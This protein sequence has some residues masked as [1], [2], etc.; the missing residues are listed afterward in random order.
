VCYQ[1]DDLSRPPERTA[2]P[3][4]ILTVLAVAAGLLRAWP[5]LR[6]G[7]WQVPVDYDEGVYSSAA[8]LLFRGVLP[9]RD[10]VFVHPPG[11]L[12]FLGTSALIPKLDPAQ[13]F[14]ASRFIAAAVGGFSVFLVGRLAW[15]WRGPVAGV[16]A[17]LLYATY[18]E[19][20]ALEHGPFLEPVL[21][22][23]CLAGAAVWLG[24][25]SKRSAWGA[26]AVLGYAVSVKLTGAV[27]VLAALSAVPKEDKKLAIHLLAAVA[28]SAAVFLLPLALSAP[29]EFFSQVVLFH[30][31]RPVDGMDSRATRAAEMLFSFRPGAGVLSLIGALLALRQ[32][33]RDR[34]AR[35]WL[36]GF[37]LVAFSFLAT[38]TYWTQYNAFFAPAQVLLAGAGAAALWNFASERSG[39]IGAIATALLLTAGVFPSLRRIVLKGRM[40]EERLATLSAYARS[41]LPADACVFGFEPAWALATGRLPYHQRGL[42]PLVDPYASMLM[43]VGTK[44]SSV[45]AA[46]ETEAARAPVAKHLAEC[47]YVVLGWR[48]EWQLGGAGRAQFY[49]RFDRLPL[50]QTGLD[51]WRRR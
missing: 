36:V 40:H 15:S 50:E 10:F 8:Q 46:F 38:S 20:V 44:V 7:A 29:N 28:L 41:Q 48:G 34:G 3:A 35:L 11:L 22:L 45:D 30:L 1:A 47:S 16:V 2:S 39:R 12:Y 14:A 6:W 33:A 17:A 37:A 23:V 43:A 27:F 31:H 26:G 5:L 13:V 24:A 32:F 42:A 18:P 9:Y 21:N 25:P 19:A 4:L 49:E 51:L